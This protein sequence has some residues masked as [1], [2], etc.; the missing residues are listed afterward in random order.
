MARH[1]LPEGVPHFRAIAGDG[2]VAIAPP[3]PLP[4][5]NATDFDAGP[6]VADGSSLAAQRAVTRTIAGESYR[7]NAESFF[8]TNTELLPQ[9]IDAALGSASGEVA[10][11]LYCGVG[12]FTLP[13]ARKFKQVTAVED[14]TSAARFARKNV[15]SAGLTNARI[16]K[17]DVSQWLARACGLV[18]PGERPRSRSFA[19]AI[20]FLLLDPPRTGAESRVIN[21]ILKLKP[22]QI[23]YVSCDPATLARDLRKLLTDG[24]SLDSIVAFDMFPQTHHVETVV[25]LS[26]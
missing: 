1:A 13:L 5:E 18:G 12:L 16:E 23:C 7:L 20:D 11:E 8:Q 4:P 9:L 19:S 17:S 6:N 24:Y 21:G 26:G 2:S 10:V 15:A 22:K 3:V 14:D 25:H